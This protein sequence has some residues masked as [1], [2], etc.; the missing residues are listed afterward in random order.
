M[1]H[2]YDS[3]L[4]IALVSPPVKGDSSKLAVRISLSLNLSGRRHRQHFRVDRQVWP[5]VR[6]NASKCRI[7]HSTRP[8]AAVDVSHFYYSK[9]LAYNIKKELLLTFVP[10]AI[11]FGHTYAF[12]RRKGARRYRSVAAILVEWQH[13]SR[14]SDRGGRRK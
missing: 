11:R 6:I 8:P 13:P 2:H 4:T 10:R 1:T 9:V 7:L 14:G 5:V 12:C 3:S